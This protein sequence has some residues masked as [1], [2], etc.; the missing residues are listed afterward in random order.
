MCFLALIHPRPSSILP[1]Y[2]AKSRV[3]TTSVDVQP[4]C[5]HIGMLLPRLDVMGSDYT[6][7]YR[8]ADDVVFH[9]YLPRTPAAETVGSHLDSSF[10]IFP[11]N[12]VVVDRW[13]QEALHLSEETELIYIFRQRHRYGS[14]FFRRPLVFHRC[15][16]EYRPYASLAR[17]FPFHFAFFAH[18]AKLAIPGTPV[19]RGAWSAPVVKD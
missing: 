7:L 10:V 4:F 8:I 14:A 5:Q 9:V 3:R 18:A 12:G 16:V 17:E 11:D 19:L 2:L 6:T 1:A 13:R 15:N